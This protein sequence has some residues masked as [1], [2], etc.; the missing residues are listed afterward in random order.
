METLAPS[1]WRAEGVINPGC[2][3]R[4]VLRPSQDPGRTHNTLRQVPISRLFCPSDRRAALAPPCYRWDALLW[5]NTQSLRAQKRWCWLQGKCKGWERSRRRNV[6]RQSCADQRASQQPG[7]SARARKRLLR[8][9]FARQIGRVYK[10]RVLWSRTF[11]VAYCGGAPLECK[12]RCTLDSKS[13]LNWTP[14]P[15]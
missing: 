4:W 9:V 15:V 13:D 8:K 5:A 12:I 2:P 11:F 10:D 14:S 1:G 3:S 7:G 6:K